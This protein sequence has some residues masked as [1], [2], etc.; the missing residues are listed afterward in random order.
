MQM[1]S[2]SSIQVFSRMWSLEQTATRCLCGDNFFLKL[3]MDSSVSELHKAA[4]LQRNKDP[5]V[6]L[7]PE[8]VIWLFLCRSNPFSRSAKATVPEEDELEIFVERVGSSAF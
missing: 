5:D 7:W 6:V 2:S 8:P 4:P 3:E 1:S